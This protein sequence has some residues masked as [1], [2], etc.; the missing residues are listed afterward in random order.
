MDHFGFN[1][2]DFCDVLVYVLIESFDFYTHRGE[3]G[4]SD[5]TKNL[6]MEIPQVIRLSL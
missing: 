6:V 2:L 4:N 3:Y 1:L 5:S